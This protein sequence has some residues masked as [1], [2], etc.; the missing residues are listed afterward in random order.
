MLDKY[1]HGHRDPRVKKEFETKL[2]EY[3]E[4]EGADMADVVLQIGALNFGANLKTFK[5]NFIGDAGVGKTSLVRRLSG[6]SFSN[7]YIATMGARVDNVLLQTNKGYCV[8]LEVWDSS[9]CERTPGIGDGYFVGSHGCIVMFDMSSGVSFNNLFK[10]HRSYTGVRADA[11]VV[12]LGNKTDVKDRKVKPDRANAQIR[13][14][15]NLPYFEVSVKTGANV[16][17]ACLSLVRRLTGDSSIEFAKPLSLQ[18]GPL[19]A[20]EDDRI[21]R[22]GDVKVAAAEPLPEEDAEGL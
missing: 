14:R 9:G 2:H 1:P 8:R 4:T 15:K 16:D 20:D 17:K 6:S 22:A 10:W 11:P 18:L 3:V 12:V 13:R 19:K 7:K 5:V 21:I